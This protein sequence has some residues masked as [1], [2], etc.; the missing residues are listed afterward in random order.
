MESKI[1]NIL[2]NSKCLTWGNLEVYFTSEI[3]E[4]D[5]KPYQFNHYKEAYILANFRLSSLDGIKDIGSKKVK[6]FL[7]TDNGLYK[8]I[9][10]DSGM[11][12]VTD[13]DLVQR[14]GFVSEGMYIGYIDSKVLLRYLPPRS[15]QLDSLCHEFT[16][17]LLPQYL[18]LD[19]DVYNGYWNREFDEGFAVLLNSQFGYLYNLKKDYIPKFDIISIKYLKE[20]GFF[21]VDGRFVDKNFEYQYCA[22]VVSRIDEVVREHEGYMSEIP[23]SGIYGFMKENGS[24]GRDIETDLKDLLGIDVLDIERGVREE[25]GI[26]V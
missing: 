11:N 4:K 8:D 24:S 17:I 7:T 23:L 21:T 1:P 25:V 22:L 10:K 3:S 26:V 9:L 16:H 15:S 18:G 6:I 13:K 5:L 20:N 12:W 2:E 14:F 19:R